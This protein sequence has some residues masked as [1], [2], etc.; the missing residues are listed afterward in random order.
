MRRIFDNLGVQRRERERKRVA[1]FPRAL[2]RLFLFD[3]GSDK[4]RATFFVVEGSRLNHEYELCV[5]A[6]RGL[7]KIPRRSL[8][9]GDNLMNHED[10]VQSSLPCPIVDCSRYLAGLSWTTI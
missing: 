5:I 3:D 8:I 6:N 7:R 10:E 9:M 2:A 4:I 1:R